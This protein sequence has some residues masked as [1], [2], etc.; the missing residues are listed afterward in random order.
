MTN[1]ELIQTADTET[2]AAFLHRMQAL[3]ILG[4]QADT[5][6]FLLKWLGEEE[7]ES[8]DEC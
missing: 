6:D 3:A 2:L 8:N 7:E 1:Q 5:E 4:G